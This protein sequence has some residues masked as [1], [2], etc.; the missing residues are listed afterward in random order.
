[1]DLIFAVKDIEVLSQSV[2]AH[3][4]FDYPTDKKKVKVSR[5]FTYNVDEPISS[6]GIEASVIF[7]WVR[8]ENVQHTLCSFDVKTTFVIKDFKDYL[9]D[10]Q[11]VKN[12]L[13][14]PLINI[15]FSHARAIQAMQTK[16]T[17]IEKIYI[18]V[19]E[20]DPKNFKI[21]ESKS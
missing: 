13:L 9:D 1:M 19:D 2:D 18:P 16:G 20:I 7:T 21:T 15:A 11:G 3:K 12:E 4:S 5:W 8:A 6:L 14:K 10:V 17:S